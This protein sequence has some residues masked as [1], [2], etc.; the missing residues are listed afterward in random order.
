VTA[1]DRVA[2][3]RAAQD[4]V[5]AEVLSSSSTFPTYEVPAFVA[6]RFPEF[7]PADP[8]TWPEPDRCTDGRPW[9]HSAY[10]YGSGRNSPD[11][12]ADRWRSYLREVDTPPAAR[13]RRSACRNRWKHDDS[14]L[15]GVHDKPWRDARIR[16]VRRQ[17]ARA[18]ELRHLD[19]AK[20]LGAYGIVAD[21]T[22][23]AVTLTADAAEEVIRLL[24]AYE[25]AAPL[26]I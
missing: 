23:H 2:E 25:R 6:D 8:S 4:E 24:E 18:R 13:F 12:I 22:P 1:P 9:G 15:C 19:L 21:G 3:L 10:E 26:G 17:A 20:R 7:D 16:S 5:D 11:A 14:R